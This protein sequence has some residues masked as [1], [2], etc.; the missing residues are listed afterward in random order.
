MNE[1]PYTALNTIKRES[2]FWTLSHLRAEGVL[3]HRRRG[4]WR[5]RKGAI[6]ELEN[7]KAF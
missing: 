2:L 3:E 7:S 5:L 1:I 6:E 4:V